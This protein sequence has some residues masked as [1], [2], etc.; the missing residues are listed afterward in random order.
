MLLICCCVRKCIRLV[1]VNGGWYGSGKVMLL[2]VD[3]LV[4][5]CSC[6]GLRL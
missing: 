4:F 6:S 3:V 5:L 2:L 1:Y